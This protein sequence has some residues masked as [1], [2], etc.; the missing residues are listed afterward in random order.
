[1]MKEKSITVGAD[2]GGTNTVIGVVDD[3]NKCLYENSFLT[4]PEKGVDD[5]IKRLA[6]AINSSV[7]SLN[8]MHELLG[9]GLAAPSANYHKGTIEDSANLKWK[10]VNVIE[11]M[12]KYFN[13]PTV[14]INDANAAAI[15]EQTFGSAKGMKNFLVI[16]LGTGLGS[17]IVV[18]GHLLYGEN[19]LAGEMGHAIVEANGRECSCGRAGCL[20]T[21]ISAKGLVRTAYEF[22]STCD[23]YSE[24]R[25]IPYTQLSGKLISEFALKNDEIALR[26]FDYTGEILGRVLSNVVTYFNPEAIILYGGLAE[27]EELLL[28]PLQFYFDKYLLGIYKGKVKLLKSELQHGKAAI[29]GASSFVRK[30]INNK[31]ESKV[32]NDVITTL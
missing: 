13:V 30:H 4:Q 7:T 17:G 3:Q 26:T 20:E 5:F 11:K 32:L 2:I 10:N 6:E 28:K 31:L 25:N 22:M 18:D 29:L 1:M 24:L 12:E 19:G 16:T 15:G 23:D 27:A 9:I 14:L 21:Y 8:N